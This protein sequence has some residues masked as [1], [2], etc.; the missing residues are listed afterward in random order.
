MTGAAGD[1]VIIPPEP[2]LEGRGS[3]AMVGTHRCNRVN[4]FT[5][6][7]PHDNYIWVATRVKF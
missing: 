6:R 5:A 4:R 3:S 2:R 1:G 7:N